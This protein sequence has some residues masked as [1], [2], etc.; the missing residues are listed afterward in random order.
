MAKQRKYFCFCLVESVKTSVGKATHLAQSSDF[1][2]ESLQLENIDHL[3]L[4]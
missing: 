4:F 2:I 1:P 3:C